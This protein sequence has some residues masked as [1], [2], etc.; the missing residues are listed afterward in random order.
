[1]QVLPEVQKEVEVLIN[2]LDTLAIEKEQANAKVYFN[3]SRN[4]YKKIE[5]FVEYYFSGLSR[6]INGPALP[7]IDA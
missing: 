2:W 6:R 7:E 4:Q 3:H 1:M 5:P